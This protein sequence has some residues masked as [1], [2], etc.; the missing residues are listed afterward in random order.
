VLLHEQPGGLLVVEAGLAEHGHGNLL[1][2]G[3][4]HARWVKQ[5]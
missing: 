5:V 4:Y 1:R 3:G 2:K